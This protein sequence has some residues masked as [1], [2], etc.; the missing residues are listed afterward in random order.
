MPKIAPELSALV[1]GRIKEDGDHHVGGVPGLLLRVKGPSR[2]WVL[3]I[4]TDDRRVN[5][6]LGT[7]PAVSLAAARDKA[8]ERRKQ[9][10]AGAE[11]LTRSDRRLVALAAI[12]AA[13]PLV[14]FRQAAA[15]LLE[16]RKTTWK[17]VKHGDQWANTLETYAFPTLGDKDVPSITV[18][19][20]L[21]ALQP[22][23]YTKPE[24]A[25][26]VR[27]RVEAVID[28]A[29]VKH[30]LAMQNPARWKGNLDVLLPI[31]SKVRRVKHHKAV[32]WAE[33]PQAFAL[34]RSRAGV[35]A[36]ALQAV[37][38]SAARHSEVTGMLKREVRLAEKLW[39][40]SSDRMKYPRDHYVPLSD[41]LA[42]LL[43]GA[44]AG[45]GDP[46]E[47]VFGSPMPTRKG[48][49]LS[50]NSLIDVLDAVKIDAT[51]HGWRS[52]F[53]DW[54]SEAT[55]Y[56]NEVSEMALAHTI[57]NKAEAAYRRGDMLE[58]RR[59]MMQDWADYLTGKKKP[60]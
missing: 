55:S 10:E 52:T 9:I 58:K 7:Y 16:S 18:A 13:K 38:L 49:P 47:L 32:P 42:D 51:T 8:R 39:V 22:I 20:V 11:V 56:A 3:R 37:I 24:T 34:V 23:W 31:K 46:D 30:Q 28:Y 45:G 35:A 4:R 27:G 19:D 1:V 40:V 48:K 15:D 25:S 57:E 21:G 29:C 12:E 33:A 54:A 17:N 6:G 50:E 2:V 36:K 44:G 53:K 14:L 41:E 5:L 59:A 60:A 26:R 43:R